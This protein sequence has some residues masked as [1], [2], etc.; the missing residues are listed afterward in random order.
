MDG[1]VSV[2]LVGTDLTANQ[3]VVVNI[4]DEGVAIRIDVP[5]PAGESVQV[6]SGD[7]LM[8]AEVKHCHPVDGGF[9]VGFQI[10]DWANKGVLKEFVRSFDGVPA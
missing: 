8:V 6:D 2:W 4:S 5:L 1:A 10:F 7:D 9:L 3:G